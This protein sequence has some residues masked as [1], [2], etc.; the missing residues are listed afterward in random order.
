MTEAIPDLAG[1]DEAARFRRLLEQ[2]PGV[3]LEFTS[4]ADGLHFRYLSPSIEDLIGYPAERWLERPTWWVEVIHPEDRR[5]VLDVWER[6]A[7]RGD[8]FRLVYRLR[9]A[10]GSTVWVLEDTRPIRDARGEVEAW[11]GLCLDVTAEHHAREADEASQAQ[12]LE[13]EDRFRA[14]IEALP[15]VVYLEELPEPGPRYVSANVEQLLGYR[16]ED[17]VADRSLW[18][19]LVH[20][21]DRERVLEVWRRTSPKTE[22]PYIAEYRMVHADGHIVWVHDRANGWRRPDG[23]IVWQGIVGDITRRKEAEE[24]ASLADRRLRNLVEGLPVVVYAVEDAMAPRFLYLSP[25]ADDLLGIDRQGALRGE[26]PF[27]SFIHPDD[28]ARA[29]E[30]WETAL[31]ERSRFD[32]EYRVPRADGRFMWIH[33]SCLLVHDDDG[34]AYWQ[35]VMLDVTGEKRAVEGLALSEGRFRALVEQLPAVVYLVT[36]DVHSRTLYVSPKLQDLIGVPDPPP[37][38]LGEGWLDLVHPEDRDRLLEAGVRSVGS[39]EPFELEYRIIRPD[40]SVLWLRDSGVRVRSGDGRVWQGVLQDV[41]ATKRAQLEL[42]GSEARHRA[43]VEN[44]PAVVYEMDPGDER[45]TIYVSERIEELLGYSRQEWLNQPD[46]WIELLHIDDR[47]IELA[48]HDLQSTTG[49][50]WSREYRLI[51]ADGHI[52]W[53]RD[54]ATLV[55]DEG[56]TPI[57]WY[58]VML[59]ISGQKAAEDA[60]RIVNEELEMRVL[61]RTAE[62]EDANE[63]MSLEIGERRRAER[64]LLH[65]EERYRHLVEL[66]PAVVYVWQIQGRAERQHLA[67]ISPQIERLLGYSVDEWRWGFWRERLHPHD[68]AMVEAAVA[69]SEETGEPFELEYRYLTKD[70]GVVWVNDRATLIARN[71]DGLPL[72]FQGVMIDI[73]P[74]KEA[75]HAAEES[76]E[77]MLRMFD[78]LPVVAYVSAADRPEL[79]EYIGSQISS[80]LRVPPGASVDGWLNAVHPDDADVI[81]DLQRLQA[82]GEPWRV[83]YRVFARDGAIVWLEDRGRCTGRDARGRPL[84]LHGVLLDVTARREQ[85]AEDGVELDLL[86]GV[87]TGMPGIAWTES[88]DARTGRSELVYVSPPSIDML[89]YSPEELL[90]EPEGAPMLIHPEDRE[91]VLAGSASANRSQDGRWEDEYRMVRRDGSVIW[92]RARGRRQTPWGVEPQV[93]QGVTV[94]VSRLHPPEPAQRLK[95]TERSPDA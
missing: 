55:K 36:D 50:P 20:P 13:T 73:T 68:L 95:A 61:T 52:V 94:D 44:I 66:S 89:G 85:E 17:L 63:L 51:A 11:Q 75:Q 21:D 70:G 83:E 39:G 14:L 22:G 45:R 58:G 77:Q 4:E 37:V 32:A 82:T 87:I 92:V 3:V 49:E 25:N 40:G 78:Q 29:W 9:H 86:R 34:T 41:T 65:A 33:D 26:N 5:R 46:M 56:G 76:Q 2:T 71:D 30:A 79:P 54:Q 10:D 60:L 62:L 74:A 31:R 69:K 67:Y 53:I 19:R 90:R 64:E 18:P 28:R 88:V 1:E 38:G 12:L 24:A 91:R 72:A 42:A 93:W 80:L 84:V 81:E 57:T 35:G 27:P 6:C 47:E 43:L 7:A 48:A 59:D 23:T 8:P 15:V 16:A